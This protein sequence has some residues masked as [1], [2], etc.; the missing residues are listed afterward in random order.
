MYWIARGVLED[1]P[2][3]LAALAAGCGEHNVNILGLQVFP[4]GDGRVLDELVLQTSDRVT[5]RALEAL[6]D[7]AGLQDAV[8]SASSA[9]A[10]EDQPVRYLR[11]AAMVA[12]QPH[13]LEE[14]L[15]ALGGNQ[16][17]GTPT[18][19]A[20]RSAFSD[21]VAAAMLG[22]EDRG[23]GLCDQPDPQRL[24]LREA[25][26]ADAAGLIALH[27]RC[28]AGTLCRR[29]H[30]P[31]P[32]LT[33]DVARQLLEPA[34]GRSVVL[35]DGDAL[36]AHGMVAAGPDGLDLGLLVEDRWQRLGLGTRLLHTL[37]QGATSTGHRSLTCLVQRDNQA[38]LGVVQRA[39]LRARAR[40][41]DG[42]VRITIPLP[43]QTPREHPRRPSPGTITTPLVDLLHRR[44]E[45]RE[46]HPLADLIDQT[47][48]GGA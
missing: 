46:I 16:G 48:R 23:T 30:A 27:L 2:G 41:E 21:L 33:P 28:S 36:V 19:Q 22:P 3:T 15:R 12:R 9:H 32:R 20:R 34:G 1:R 11:A 18:E 10:L 6:C 14:Q 31:M 42:F 40:T 7:R 35:V 8:V 4:T 38:M 13:R 26:A 5:A 17:A 39:G 24:V 45:L 44:P 25:N 47:V 29:Y 37:V 43:R